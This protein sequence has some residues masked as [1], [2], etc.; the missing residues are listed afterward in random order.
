[1]PERDY[2]TATDFYRFLQCPHWPYYERHATEE[3]KKRKRVLSE[4]E[5]KRME[6]GLLHE[7][8]V[9]QALYPNMTILQ[10]TVEGMTLEEAWQQTQGLMAQG[11]SLIY[12]GTLLHGDWVGRPDLLERREGESVF[13][14]W[15]YVPVD[16]KSTHILEKYQKLQLTF[17]A[18]LLEKIQGRFPAQPAIINR[19]GERIDFWAS[20]FFTEFQTFLAELERI[21]GGEKPEPVL[22]KNCFDTGP[23][24]T[25][26]LRDAYNAHDIALLFNV[27]VSRLKLLR[28]LGIRTIEDAAEMDPVALDGAG[29]GLRLHGLEVMKR[30]AQSLVHAS[31]MVR[32]VV[33]FPET[34]LE[35]FFDIESDP[36]QDID[37]LYGFLVRQQGKETYRAF[38]ARTVAE[39]G[40]MWREFLAWLETLP[41][42]YAVYHFSAYEM[43]R[44]A[45]LE[46]RYGGSQWLELFRANM[47]DLK[48]VVSHSVTFPL[49]FY[50]LKYIAKFLGFSWRGEVENGSQSVDV[51]EAFLQAKDEKIFQ[52]LLTYNED[53]VLATAFLK[54]WLAKYARDLVS[55]TLPY[56][57]QTS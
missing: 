25:L 39:E 50:G 53:D 26:C 29:K 6:H 24:G 7:K 4:S 17:Y 52:S 41:A 9:V 51:F 35:L 46:K 40:E 14:N 12:Q 11:V 19:D 28:S 48:E 34:G 32:E 21:R 8:D 43:Q 33:T 37:Y 15:Y 10:A 47:I 45:V 13:G 30:Q 31:V 22:R 42:E 18:Q 20:E 56:P 38:S 44:L 54:D 23:W 16:V 3:E 27:D 55:Y 2:L 57:W 49:Y 5:E 1:M 36:P